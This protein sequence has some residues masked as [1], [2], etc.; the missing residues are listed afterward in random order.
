MCVCKNRSFTA[1]SAFI[2][3]LLIGWAV[4]TPLNAQT[5][6]GST[7]LQGLTDT[8][9]QTTQ[10][11]TQ[12]TVTQSQTTLAAQ[13]LTSMTAQHLLLALSS[14]DYPA[15]PGDIYTLAYYASGTLGDVITPLA[16]DADY[17]LKV[18]NM[19]TLS[20]RGKTYMQF[21]NEVVNLV[22]RNYPMSGASLTLTQLGLFSVSVTGETLT[23]GNYVVDG[24]TRL[25]DLKENLILTDKSST[26]FVTVTPANGA[27]RTYDLFRAI[28]DGISAENPYV[29]PGDRIVFPAAGRIVTVTGQIFR[30]DLYEL[31]PGEGLPALIEQYGGGFTRNADTT[32]IT[33]ARI[34]T[35]EGIPGET[36]IVSYKE[37]AGLTLEDGDAITILNKEAARPVAFFRGALSAAITDTTDAAVSVVEEKIPNEEEETSR[38]EYPFYEGETLGNAVRTIRRQFLPSADLTNA[39]IIRY[40]KQIAVDLREFVYGNDFSHDMALENGDFIIIPFYQFFVLV[41]GAVVNP[42]RYP[43]V[44]DRQADYYINLAGG[45]DQAKSNGLGVRVTD[46]NNKRV[47]KNEFIQPESMIYLPAKFA[48]QFNQYAPIVTTILSIITTTLAILTTTGVWTK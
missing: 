20:A 28:R 36:K 33:L 10:N 14:T 5:S 8:Q 9:G 39:Y 38:V 13:R 47:G 2:A 21:R 3:A 46:I 23:P 19:G 16:L 24:L 42:G 37:S 44:P 12:S 31:L 30:P 29:H 40:G 43:Y 6:S 45:R 1:S 11:T 35:P 15:T 26:R 48:Y 17:Q 4:S 18:Q 32:R 34:N 22:S 7:L 27:S 25:S 41:S